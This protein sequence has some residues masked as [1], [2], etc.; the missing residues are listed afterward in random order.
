MAYPSW[1][2]KNVPKSAAGL[3][4]RAY[5]DDS[6]RTVC[7]SALCPNRGE[8][9]ARRTVT[10]LLLGGVCTRG[11][12]FC[13]VTKAAPE[14]VDADEPQKI[15]QAARKLGLRHIVIT[16]VTRDDLPDGGAAH[17]AAA[18]LAARQGLPR[19]AVEVLTPDFQGSLGALDKVLAASPDVFN[20][21]V[22]TV[23]RLYAAIRPQADY[24]R[25]LNILRHAAQSGIL[26]KTGLMLGLGE[27]EAEIKS[28]LQDLKDSGASIVTLGQYLPPSP[29]HYPVQEFVHPDKFAEYQEYGEKELG[30]KAVF[31]GPF[32]RSSY[33]AAEVYLSV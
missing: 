16:S 20:H 31:S 29:K 23:P 10:F 6:L 33:R 17:F 22:E 30:F 8:C 32:V 12:R 13:A 21:N 9:F 26:T 4:I 28:T 7:E 1:L 27:T 25:S 18:I 2:K 15:A 19:A 14:P 5:L 24:Q 3:R 11:C